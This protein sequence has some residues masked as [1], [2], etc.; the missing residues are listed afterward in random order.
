MS[1]MRNAERSEAVSDARR[2]AAARLG[3]LND[4]GGRG[5]RR[6]EGRKE[7]MK[8]GRKAYRELRDHV[9]GGLAAH[10]QGKTKPDLLG[11]SKPATE[12]A[13]RALPWET[14]ARGN[15]AMSAQKTDPNAARCGQ[16]IILELNTLSVASGAAEV[17]GDVDR[18]RVG[19]VPEERTTRGI[20][21]AD[22][23]MYE[24]RAEDNPSL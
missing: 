8:E 24:K 23:P 4:A 17:H 19:E 14:R 7:G 15:D 16:Q 5:S 6:E 12:C 1:S 9:H 21:S 11:M 2:M 3:E 22:W 20:P 18:R 13:L 10:R